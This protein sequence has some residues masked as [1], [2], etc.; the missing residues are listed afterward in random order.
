MSKIL[1]ECSKCGKTFINNGNRDGLNCDKCK[2]SLIPLGCV[3]ELQ[4][5]IDTMKDKIENADKQYMLN[6]KSKV[7]DLTIKLNLDTTEFENKL[8]R[9][10]KKLTRIKDLEDMLRFDKSLNE[11]KNIAIN[12]NVD[13]KDIMKRCVEAAMSMEPLR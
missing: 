10:E 8:D 11:V 4:N 13:I 2:G 1:Y 6:K 5:S 9:M 7:K 3:D 12:N